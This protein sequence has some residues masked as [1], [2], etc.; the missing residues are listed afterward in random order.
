MYTTGTAVPVDLPLP[1]SFVRDRLPFSNSSVK[2]GGLFG[3]PTVNYQIFAPLGIPLGRSFSQEIPQ[4]KTDTRGSYTMN[5]RA[6]IFPFFNPGFHAW[7]CE[8]WEE[9]GRNSP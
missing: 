7:E 8:Y 4:D 9:D 6:I 2:G 5:E 1:Q 3:A